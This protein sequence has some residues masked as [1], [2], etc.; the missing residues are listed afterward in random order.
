MLGP[1][2]G[3]SGRRK[4]FAAVKLNTKKKSAIACCKSN[5]LSNTSSFPVLSFF[6]P[7]LWFGLEYFLPA[8]LSFFIP[9]HLTGPVDFRAAHFQ[10]SIP[11]ILQLGRHDSKNGRISNNTDKRL[12]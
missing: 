12:T 1:D 2:I 8:F 7:S 4:P 10:N 11:I 6:F 3:G 9:F 5:C